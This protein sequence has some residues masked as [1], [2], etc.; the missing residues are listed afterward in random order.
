MNKFQSR[1]ACLALAVLLGGLACANRPTATAPPDPAPGTAQAPYVIGVKDLLRISVWQNT[2]ITV[3]VPVRPDGKVSVPLIDDVTAA[4]LT[5]V[6]LKDVIT[7]E[8]SKSVESPDVTVIVLEINSRFVSSD[9]SPR[10]R[11]CPSPRTCAWSRRLRSRAASTSSPISATCAW[12]G[13]NPT[14][15]RSNTASTTMRICR[16]VRRTR[17]SYS[18]QGM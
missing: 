11:A 13:A 4:G 17:I 6:Q 10:P 7:K 3:D 9:A 16:V 15:R 8:L 5:P 14:A 1:T 18:R 12:Y 2:A